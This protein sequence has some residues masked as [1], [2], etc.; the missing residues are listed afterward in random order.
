MLLNLLISIVGDTFAR[1]NADKSNIM[2]RDMVDLIVE[3]YFLIN[4]ADAKSMNKGKYL[5]LV[6]PED[7]VLDE[8]ELNQ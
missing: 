3:N 7:S 8:E 4:S 6:I 5:V 1:V 2:Y